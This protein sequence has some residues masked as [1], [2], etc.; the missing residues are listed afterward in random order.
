MCIPKATWVRNSA[1]THLTHAHCK[2]KE[3][4]LLHIHY[5]LCDK[6]HDLVSSVNVVCLS[7]LQP[8][9]STC[10]VKC[11]QTDVKTISTTASGKAYPFQR[12]ILPAVSSQRQQYTIANFTQLSSSHTYLSST[13]KPPGTLHRD[14]ED[15]WHSRTPFQFQLRDE[16]T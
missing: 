10:N 15:G 9:I 5:S 12:P 6:L 3:G 14:Q 11:N 13:T 8:I 1:H 16:P 2:G 7:A 4:T